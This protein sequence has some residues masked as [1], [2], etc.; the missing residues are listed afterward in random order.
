MKNLKK[1]TAFVLA[2][3]TVISVCAF[4]VSAQEEKITDPKNLAE[5]K[6]MLDQQGYP[7]MTTEQFVNAV[8]KGFGVYRKLTFRGDEPVEH[9][10]FV[11]DEIIQSFCKEIADETGLDLLLMTS[12]LPESNNYVA[13]VMDTFQIDTVALREAAFKIKDEKYAEGNSLLGKLFYFFGVYLSIIEKCEAYCAPAPELGKDCYEIH[14]RITMRDGATEDKETGIIINT[15]TGEVFDR[16]GNG[17]VGTGYNFSTAD[18][19]VYTLPNAWV[20]D[21]GF[22]FLYDLFSYTTPFFFYETRRIKFDY[23]G[24]DWM[25]QVWKGNYLVSNGAEVGLYNRDKIRFGTL[26]DCASDE[27]MLEMSMQLYHGDEFIFGRESQ[28][29]WWLTGFRIS[30]TLYTANSMTLKFTITMKDAE[31]LKAFCESIDKHYKKDM[32]YTVDG[33]TVSVVW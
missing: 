1:L 11:T 9:F 30:D 31:M 22:C 19:L 13:M 24:K 26:Y 3:A 10:N 15:A 20:R 21:F 18:M 29:H 17:L 25:V 5:Y 27:D 33:L 6:E 28:K 12:N 16:Y 7:A 32:S 8:K 2:L 4:G 23:E 14:L